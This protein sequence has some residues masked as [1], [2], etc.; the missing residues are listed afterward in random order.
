MTHKQK[1][2]LLRLARGAAYSALATIIAYFADANFLKGLGVAPAL[3]PLLTGLALSADKAI[4]DKN[5]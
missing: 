1:S 3:I 4:R 5:K 2:M